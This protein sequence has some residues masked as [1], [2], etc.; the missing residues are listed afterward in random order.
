MEPPSWLTHNIQIL[1][2]SGFCGSI[3]RVLIR[4]EKQWQ[5]WLVQVLVG[6]TAAVFL[7]S[8][9]GHIISN[10]IGHEGSTAAYLASGF[11]IGTAAERA[12]EKLQAKFLD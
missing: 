9:F 3:V 12:I 1:L 5:R 6:T 8:I 11:L 2:T 7:G 4:P 10:M